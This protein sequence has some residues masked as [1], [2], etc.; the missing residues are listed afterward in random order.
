MLPDSLE[1]ILAPVEWFDVSGNRLHCNCELAW[2]RRWFGSPALAS[3][4]PGGGRSLRCRGPGTP[5]PLLDRSVSD[6]ACSGP[7]IQSSTPSRN[8][9][10]G[11]DVVLACTA[12]GEPTPNV[13]WASPFGDVVSITPPD[14]RQQQRLSAIWQIRR[15]RAHHSGWYRYRVLQMTF[16]MQYK[17]L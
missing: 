8:V 15:A 5:G 11:S 7:V 13:K 4:H 3:R 9:P 12:E 6:F 2:L 14:D 10:A 16:T 1:T 17:L